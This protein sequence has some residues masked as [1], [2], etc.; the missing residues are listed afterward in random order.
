MEEIQV[1][2][3]FAEVGPDETVVLC[4]VPVCDLIKS[5]DGQ[6]KRIVRGFGTTESEDRD[7][8]TLLLNGLD[9]SQLR[10]DGYINYD[11]QRVN[12][13]GAKMPIIIGV[14]TLVEMRPKGLW[15]EGEL[16]N[17]DPKKS[18]QDRLANEMWELG[19]N[20]QGV[21]R[22][23]SYSIEGKILQRHGGRLVKTK[24]SQVAL[25]HKPVNRECSVELLAKSFCCGACSTE[26]AEYNPAHTCSRKRA[27][28]P[29]DGIP[30][31]VTALEKAAST[32]VHGALLRENLDR[33]L[34]SILY[35]DK[36]CG[37][38]DASTGRFAKGISGAH[39]HL[40]RCLGYSS[41]DSY[42]LLDKIVQ[43]ASK[44]A[45]FAV[46]AKTAGLIRP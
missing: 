27:A 40:T 5:D 8:E 13:G 4:E 29:K 41:N 16:F 42:R 9:F 45:D 10:D 26:C 35:G 38:Y 2:S 6:G 33:G 30:Y 37:C 43:G 31:L 36:P 39:E 14:P 22:N 17:G 46:L 44:S 32:A 11:H 15:V 7:A 21:G 34:T 3:R 18:E 24:A 25:T 12:I 1:P 28:T 23:L 20:L 19:Q